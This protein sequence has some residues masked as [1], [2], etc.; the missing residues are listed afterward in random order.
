MP[1]GEVYAVAQQGDSTDLHGNKTGMVGGE[2]KE[3]Q[4]GVKDMFIDI[5]PPT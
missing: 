5:P 3:L 1:D 4:D 2:E